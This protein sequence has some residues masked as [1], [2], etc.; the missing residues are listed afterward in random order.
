MSKNIRMT[1]PSVE[2]LVKIR[3]ARNAIASQKP[4]MVKCP[5]C[6]HNSIIVF[7]DT[8]GHVQAKCKACGRETVFDV[9]SMRRF[10]LRHP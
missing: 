1:E 7:E 6:K 9:L 3:M 10:Q 2:M 5:Y 4:R 8:R